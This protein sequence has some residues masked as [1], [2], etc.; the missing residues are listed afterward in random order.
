MF[1]SF[2]LNPDY[3]SLGEAVVMF[4]IDQGWIVNEYYLKTF[5]YEG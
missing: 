5:T 3:N 1:S 4:M 2:G